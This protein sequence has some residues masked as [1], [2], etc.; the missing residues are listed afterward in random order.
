MNGKQVDWM[1]GSWGKLGC[2]IGMEGKNEDGE[3]RKYDRTQ[4]FSNFDVLWW[5]NMALLCPWACTWSW[6]CTLVSP[7][8]C[9]MLLLVWR[10]PRHGRDVWP[11]LIILHFFSWPSIPPPTPHSFLLFISLSRWVSL[12]FWGPV[13]MWP[14]QGVMGCSSILK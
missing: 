7:C 11:S 5:M 12:S 4:W 2:M 13:S 6:T 9:N 3:W 8:L 14:S 10:N 1:G